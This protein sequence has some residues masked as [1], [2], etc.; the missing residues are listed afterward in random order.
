MTTDLQTG[1]SDQQVAANRQEY[2]ANQLEVKKKT[3]LFDKILDVLRSPVFALLI[4]AV[5]I[6]FLIGELIDAVMIAASMGFIVT[7]EIW[8]NYRTDKSLAA[9]AQLAAPQVEV[10]RDSERQTVSSDDLV[11]GDVV[12]LQEGV[13]IPAD[14]VV[15]DGIDLKVNESTLTGEPEPILKAPVDADLPPAQV[16][17]DRHICYAGTFVVSGSA[18]VV[19]KKVGLATRYGQIAHSLATIDDRPTMMQRQIGKLVKYSS[20][21]A[22]FCFVLVTIITYFNLAKTWD[23]SAFTQ[24]LTAGVTIAIALIP[25]E[26]PVVLT[27][28]LSMGA[29]RL[30]QK[31]AL[32]RKLS[33]VETLGSVS[34][35]CVDKTGTLTM[36]QM[37]VEEAWTPRYDT[38]EA[39]ELLALACEVEAYDP[40]EQAMLEYCRET[41]WQDRR[42]TDYQQVVDYSFTD[43][44]KMMGQG[45]QID[46]QIVVAVKGAPER[47]FKLCQLSSAQSDDLHLRLE[48]AASDGQRVIALAQ[49]VFADKSKI[50]EEITDLKLS[51]VGLIVLS[52]PPRPGIKKQ[53]KI[54]QEAGIRVMMLTGDNPMTAVGIA[55]QVGI[56]DSSEVLTGS[57]LNKLSEKELANKLARVNIFSRVTPNHKLSL[58]KAL[59]ANGHSVAMLGDGVNDTPALRQADIGVAMSKRGSDVVREAADL[60]LLDDNFATIVAS[61]ADGR[62][63]YANIKKAVEYILAIHVPIALAALLAP[64]LKIAPADLMILPIGVMLLE[65]VIDPTCSIVLER[66][67]LEPSAMSEPPRSA[68]DSLVDRRLVGI[69]LLRGLAIFAGSFS[70][71]F[72]SLNSGLPA[73]LARTLGLSNMILANL[74]L[75]QII[76]SEHQSPIV[77]LKNLASDK[78][79]L[80][81]NGLIL[82]F[83]LIIIY[84]P[85]NGFLR[86][87]SLRPEQLAL[88][89]F[90]AALST[91]GFAWLIKPRRRIEQQVE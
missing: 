86:L 7:I 84:S 83:L 27:V 43:E 34:V 9:L 8:Q 64:L 56:A 17:D 10:L 47:V 44:L 54:C 89:L 4:I 45:W 23:W 55:K 20:I 87:T 5:V 52:D 38:L 22:L 33:A 91:I 39:A 31:Q 81:L 76:N 48:R 50:P 21:V 63:I 73:N 70:L 19:V 26:F 65:L 49:T 82:T 35:L 88:S 24:S 18:T 66:S 79:V 59:Q 71:Y 74:L 90:V 80:I 11:V 2:G 69:N 6:Y 12:Y 25:E 14:L 30:S 28:F 75:V 42:Q 62:R 3:T 40:M 77:T 61:V 41:G 15:V 16:K 68:T 53:L 58:V 60:V 29:W 72:L 78:V 37:Q 32:I 13:K 1:L 85:I 57:E 67:P 51:F 46:D 36:N